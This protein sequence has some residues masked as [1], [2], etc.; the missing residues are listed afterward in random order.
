[1]YSTEV[2][3]FSWIPEF[4]ITFLTQTA[5]IES[6]TWVKKESEK[7]AASL[8]PDQLAA[9]PKY[10]LGDVSRCFIIDQETQKAKYI[11]N[12]ADEPVQ[13]GATIRANISETES[14]GGPEEETPAEERV[15]HEEEL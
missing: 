2:N 10:P 7:V 5:L 1:M 14:T 11:T 13:D 4:V 3:L 12:C 8:T 6:T 9:M 15:A